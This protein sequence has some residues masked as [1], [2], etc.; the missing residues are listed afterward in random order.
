MKINKN[1]LDIAII[2]PLTHLRF[3]TEY[4]EIKDFIYY[5]TKKLCKKRKTI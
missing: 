5:E 3:N 2:R 4:L 1:T